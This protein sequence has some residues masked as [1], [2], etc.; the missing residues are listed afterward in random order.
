MTRTVIASGFAFFCALVFNVLVGSLNA[1]QDEKPLLTRPLGFYEPLNLVSMD[2]TK[3]RLDLNYN[4]SYDFFV[5]VRS[6]TNPNDFIARGEISV[7][8]LDSNKVSIAREIL[9]KELHRA[10]ELP[11][12]KGQKSI[13]GSITFSLNAGPYS[14]MFEVDDLESN[15]KMVFPHPQVKLKKISD[16]SPGNSD[17]LF[18]NL[19]ESV[20]DSVSYVYPVNLGGDVPFGSHYSILFQSAG[21][22]DSSEVTHFSVYRLDQT[23]RRTSLF[24]D[25]SRPIPKYANRPLMPL[26]GDSTLVYTLQKYSAAPRIETYLIPFPS[27][28]LPPG[29]Y[30]LE[31]KRS[32]NSVARKAFALRWLDKP[33][34]LVTVTIAAEALQYLMS[35]KEFEEF[36]KKSPE[37]M[38]KQFDEFW[39]KRD[40]TPT[41][42]YN[43]AMAEYYA[44]CDY[45]LENFGTLSQVNGIKTDRG[46]IY[47]LYG[48]PTK[49]ERMF[50]PNSPPRE[51]WDY[52][53]L[54]KRFIFVDETKAGNYKLLSSEKL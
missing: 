13:Q 25:S 15:R 38:K 22:G 18:V 49:T 7:E 48:A 8:V 6:T 9:R 4:I 29:D 26:D 35:E 31:V 46:K 24:S 32:K 33:R 17:I 45:A 28:T 52:E 5:F 36:M 2:T 54:G 51:V 14:L 12:G 10:S 19:V 53:N 1:Q 43:E 23:K 20:N 21:S 44:R 39:K 27:D 3:C 11:Q 50:I 30:D 41:T 47:V 37:E 42:A 34:S 16:S 40:P